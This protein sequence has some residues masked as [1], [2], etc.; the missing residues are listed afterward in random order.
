MVNPFLEMTPAS[1]ELLSPLAR[2][3]ATCV[4]LYLPAYQQASAT[5][6][7]DVQLRSL[8]EAARADL[9]ARGISAVDTD[10]LF[11]PLLALSREGWMERGHAHNLAVFRAPNCLEM[12]TFSGR[13]EGS[14]HTGASFHVMPV[15]EAVTAIPPE[16]WVVA[17]TRKSVRLLHGTPLGGLQERALP[18]SIP[19]TMS[20]FLAFDQPDHRR[21]NRST[22]GPSVGAMKGVAFGTGAELEVQDQHF[23]HYCVTIDRGL[24]S[25]LGLKQPLIVVGA[26]DEASIYKSVNRHPYLLPPVLRSPDDGGLSDVQ[27]ETKIRALFANSASP[28]EIRACERA[29]QVMGSKLSVTHLPSII[30]FAFQGRVDTVFLSTKATEKGNVDHITGRTRLDGEYQAL[31][32]DLYNAAAI[33]TLRHSGSVWVVP[34]ERIPGGTAVFAQL[35]Y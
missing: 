24:H 34:R 35:R 31:D 15:L 19:A 3:S 23:H 33:E 18:P 5:P 10:D 7:P 30:R 22:A 28:D 6:R 17:L 4:S 25:L 11:S 29:N 32:E 26:T 27:M 9:R 1:L 13:I 12:F 21:E 2:V 16:Y 14:V 20:E 8:S